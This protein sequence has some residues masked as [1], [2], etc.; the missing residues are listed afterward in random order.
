MEYVCNDCGHTN[1]TQCSECESEN[2]SIFPD[3]KEYI[4]YIETHF[5]KTNYP[6]DTADVFQDHILSPIIKLTYDFCRETNCSCM[7]EN[8]RHLVS[9]ALNKFDYTNTFVKK[10]IKKMI[11]TYSSMSV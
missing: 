8:I 2:I 1:I 7:E 9:I 4:K 10:S 5:N 3:T 6:N 11:D